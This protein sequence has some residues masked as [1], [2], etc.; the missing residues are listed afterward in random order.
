MY[1]QKWD[2]ENSLNRIL[3]I[4]FCQNCAALIILFICIYIVNSPCDLLVLYNYLHIHNIFFFF[5][6][7]WFRSML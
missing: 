5:L 6:L 7:T 2:F 1:T 4:F 3:K